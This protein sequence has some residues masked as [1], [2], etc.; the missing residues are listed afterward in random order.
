MITAAMTVQT[1]AADVVLA[2]GVE[3]MSNIEHYTHD[4]ALGFSVGQSD[5]L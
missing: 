3:S 1:G 4:G 2:G 5:A